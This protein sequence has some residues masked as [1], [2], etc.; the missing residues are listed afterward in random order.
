L[1]VKGFDGIQY[2]FAYVVLLNDCPQSIVPQTIEGL[3]EV[4]KVVVD[5]P[6]MFDVLL[7]KDFKIENLLYS[8]SATHE[9]R[10]FFCN[11]AVD[12]RL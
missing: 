10:L 3:L 6:V 5:F 8:A 7:T 4:D 12:L 9:S 1:A 11:M 2:F